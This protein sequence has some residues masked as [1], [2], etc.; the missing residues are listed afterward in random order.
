MVNS[1]ESIEMKLTD[2][3]I[4]MEF[5]LDALI[6]VDADSGRILGGRNKLVA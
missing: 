3:H 2:S 4:D 1:I 6:G 5:G